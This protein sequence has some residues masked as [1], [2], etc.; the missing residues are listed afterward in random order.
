MSQVLT[1]QMPGLVVETEVGARRINVENVKANLPR[2]VWHVVNKIYERR[3]T[4]DQDLCGVN[5]LGM[6]YVAASLTPRTPEGV[7][8]LSDVLRDMG[9]TCLQG[10]THRLFAY[11]YAMRQK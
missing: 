3:D 8:A 5:P 10:D 1:E 11:I 6:L 4:H 7:K 2:E 9:T